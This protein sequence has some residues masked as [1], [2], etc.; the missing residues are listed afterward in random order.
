MLR[1]AIAGGRRASEKAGSNSQFLYKKL[2]Q[3][4]TQKFLKELL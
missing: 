3:R 2:S 1:I 4:K